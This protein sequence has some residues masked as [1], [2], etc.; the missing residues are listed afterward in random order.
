MASLET[1]ECKCSHVSDSNNT[2]LRLNFIQPII[3][4]FGEKNGNFVNILDFIFEMMFS[5][6]ISCPCQRL[7]P[8]PQSRAITIPRPSSLCHQTPNGILPVKS[9]LQSNGKFCAP[10][11]V[12]RLATIDSPVTLQNGGP[13]ISMNGINQKKYSQSTFHLNT[14]NKTASRSFT[15]PW[16]YKSNGGPIDLC[17]HRGELKLKHIVND[18]KLIKVGGFYSIRVYL[19]IYCLLLI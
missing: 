12:E 9:A 4:L 14:I 19:G 6:E 3:Y 13:K 2:S 7:R 15:S 8:S 11:N 17:A 5:S 16:T 10:Y 1:R 18:Y